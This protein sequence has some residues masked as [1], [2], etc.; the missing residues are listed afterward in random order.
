[1]T[2]INETFFN[3]AGSDE[4]GGNLDEIF[5]RLFGEIQGNAADQKPPKVPSPNSNPPVKKPRKKRAKKRVYL[6]TAEP[7]PAPPVKKVAN[8]FEIAHAEIWAKLPR[9]KQL[10]I[11]EDRKAGNLNSGVMIE[12]TD[13][14]SRRA[15]EIYNKS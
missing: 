9:W 1:M 13:A 5:R 8:P 6:P 12:F 14:V 11:E 3:G 4:D 10:A 15:E 7:V 2:Y